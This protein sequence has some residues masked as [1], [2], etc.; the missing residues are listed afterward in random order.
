MSG[1]AW[2]DKA[3][4]HIRD[5]Q[6][7]S[8]QSVR[9][10]VGPPERTD[11]VQLVKD[12]VGLIHLMVPLPEG[13]DEFDVP[14]GQLLKAKWVATRDDGAQRVWLDVACTESRLLRT[15]LSLVGEMLDRAEDSGRHSLDELRE[16]LGSWRQAL[17]RIRG[18]EDHRRAIGLYGELVILERLARLDPQTALSSWRGEEGYRHDFARGNALEVKTFTGTG[19]PVVTIHGQRQL[20]A[21][22]GGELHLVALRVVESASGETLAELAGRIRE[23]GIP[24]GE[25]AGA[26]DED[27]PLLEDGRRFLVEEIFLHAVKEDFPGIRASRLDPQILLGVGAVSF[28]LSL[29]ACPGRLDP[30]Q[31]DTI[32]Q[33]L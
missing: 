31:L 12:H 13:R 18:A 26:L 22:D 2:V 8:G 3:Y 10:A 11:D 15:F 29:D 32:L 23:H 4:T 27:A 25:L 20:D 9:A 24:S 30:S 21:P 17:A 14:L 1:H 7:P 19:A 16:V 33:E 5:A 28:E 6:V